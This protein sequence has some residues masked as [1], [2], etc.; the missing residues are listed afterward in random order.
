MYGCGKKGLDDEPDKNKRLDQTMKFFILSVLFAVLSVAVQGQDI[1]SV[2]NLRWLS[3]CWESNNAERNLLI[4]EQ[5]MKPAGGTMIGAGRTVKSGKT[6]DFEFLRII[7]DASGVYYVAKPTANKEETRFKLVRATASEIIFEN[8]A[9]DFPQRI[10]YRLDGTKLLARI[11]G[12]QNGKLRGVDFPYSRI[13][14][15]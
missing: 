3:G 15:E 14:C 2:N 9:H 5:W 4:T 7:E 6:V 10:M 1:S 13:K 8:L 12:M 11:E